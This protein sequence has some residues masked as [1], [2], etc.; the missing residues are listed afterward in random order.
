MNQKI[1]AQFSKANVFFLFDHLKLI[2]AIMKSGSFKD[3]PKKNIYRC[4][5]NFDIKKLSNNLMIKLFF[6]AS[7]FY[8][9]L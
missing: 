4:Y 1:F 8:A 7:D 2:S 3:P 5:K 6:N 9:P